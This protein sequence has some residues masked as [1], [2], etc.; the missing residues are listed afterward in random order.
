LLSRYKPFLRIEMYRKLTEGQRRSLYRSVS[1]R[2]YT[3]HRI[4]S[5]HDYRGELIDENDLGR[6]KHFDAFCAPA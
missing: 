2:G 3:L 4:V 6:W 1:S 5:E